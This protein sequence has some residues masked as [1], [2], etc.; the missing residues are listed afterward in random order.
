MYNGDQGHEKE[1]QHFIV[2][3]RSLDSKDIMVQRFC[4][5][6]WNLGVKMLALK[7]HFTKKFLKE[8]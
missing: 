7:F 8:Y 5:L 4:D 2:K 6:F 1:L 3:A